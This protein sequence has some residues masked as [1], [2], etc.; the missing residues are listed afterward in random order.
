MDVKLLPDNFKSATTN[1]MVYL[2]KASIHDICKKYASYERIRTQQS[3]NSTI[4]A[5]R[6][7]LDS[8][9]DKGMVKRIKNPN[10]NWF[11]YMPIVKENTCT[12]INQKDVNVLEVKTEESQIAPEKS[13]LTIEAE[14]KFSTLDYDL[15]GIDL[16]C[17]IAAKYRSLAF[18]A[19]ARGIKFDLSLDDIQDII[20]QRRCYYTNVI[21]DDKDNL[22]T[23]DRVNHKKGYVK[24]NI[25]VCTK[26]IN[27]F[28]NEILEHKKHKMFNDVSDLK[29]FVDIL[30]ATTSESSNPLLD[31]VVPK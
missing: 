5:I 20:L 23:V 12:I 19:R 1:Q 8:L 2:R 4:T 24:D 26:N 7:V 22:K 25:V 10:T 30:Y 18:S 31:L 6:I 3:M 14:M 28:K 9:V 21:F 15:S 11:V 13:K 17:A 27:E 29:R 16:V